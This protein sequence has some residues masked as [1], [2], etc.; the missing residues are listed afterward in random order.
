MAY[1]DVS[2]GDV[3]LTA[4]LRSSRFGSKNEGD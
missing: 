3:V 1:G 2:I 4:A